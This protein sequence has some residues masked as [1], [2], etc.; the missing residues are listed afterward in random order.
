MVACMILTAEVSHI[1]QFCEMEALNN[2]WCMLPR[3]AVR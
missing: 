2:V 1:Q 3:F